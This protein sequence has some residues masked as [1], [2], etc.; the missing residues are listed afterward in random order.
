MTIGSM[1]S[2]HRAGNPI[3]RGQGS[4]LRGPFLPFS[5]WY[6]ESSEH[7]KSRIKVHCIAFSVSKV[8]L[9]KTPQRA[10]AE[11]NC[12]QTS[13]LNWRWKI[14]IAF[15]PRMRD[16]ERS[17]KVGSSIAGVQRKEVLHHKLLW[18]RISSMWWRKTRVPGKWEHEHGW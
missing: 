17:R 13:Y 12:V 7:L 16:A 18:C 4:L 14:N 10:T 5:T 6:S 3:E 9:N 2:V 8:D 1:S 11:N 15:W